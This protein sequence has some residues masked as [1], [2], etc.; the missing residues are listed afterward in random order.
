MAHPYRVLSLLLALAAP[1]CSLFRSDT[2]RAPEAPEAGEAPAPEA[3]PFPPVTQ[4]VEP[5]LLRA[6][7]E[8]K[9]LPP[10]GGQTQIIV[11]A[12]KR[13][14]D[15]YEGLEV[16]FTTSAGTLY[17]RSKVLVTDSAGRTRDRLTTRRS[18]TVTV[19]VGGTTQQ[20]PVTVAGP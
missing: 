8:P 19:D 2:P 9:L 4:A 15:P 16:R 5:V 3:T 10:A 14:G 6:W 12:R 20:I 17:S 1:A 7:A 11:L 18:A 13:N